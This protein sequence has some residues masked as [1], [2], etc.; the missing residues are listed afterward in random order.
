MKGN[1]NLPN[2]QFTSNIMTIKPLTYS[3]CSRSDSREQI[4]HSRHRIPNKFLQSNSKLY[5]G[6]SDFKP[7]SRNGSP[8]QKL[9]FENNFQYNSRPQS[10]HYN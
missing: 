10:P 6:N 3:H 1:Q 4:N 7:Q 8:Y 5:Y 2:R 9:D